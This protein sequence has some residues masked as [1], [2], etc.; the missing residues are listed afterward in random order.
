MKVCQNINS[1]KKSCF[2]VFSAPNPITTASP[3]PKV[4]PTPG[5]K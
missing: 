4:T 2:I 1:V 5:N 3:T